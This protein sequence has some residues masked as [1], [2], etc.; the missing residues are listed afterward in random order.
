MKQIIFF[1]IIILIITSCSNII[2]VNPKITF[3]N[4]SDHK[5]DSVT[6]I[7]FFK[8]KV[9]YYNIEP[10]STIDTTFYLKGI[11]YPKGDYVSFGYY[12]FKDS[13]FYSS[14]GNIIDIPFGTL[15][16]NYEFSFS[17]EGIVQMNT[18]DNKIHTY[19]HPIKITKENLE[20]YYRHFKKVNE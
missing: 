16:N 8:N 14:G 7:D 12:I 3:N 4:K 15:Q 1:L 9:T 11:E 13:V 5:L 17:N 10:K 6:I 19:N 20:Y 2:D 18:H